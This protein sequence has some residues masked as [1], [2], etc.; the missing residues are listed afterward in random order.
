MGKKSTFGGLGIGLRVGIV[1][2]AVF[3]VGIFTQ[4]YRSLTGAGNYTSIEELRAGQCYDL[5]EY[6]NA[7]IFEV[8]AADVLPCEEPHQFEMV[9]GPI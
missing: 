7:E 4:A 3:G 6:T 1:L 2:V 9:P 5:F 8:G